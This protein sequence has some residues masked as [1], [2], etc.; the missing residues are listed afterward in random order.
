MIEWSPPRTIGTGP[1]LATRYT[2]SWITRSARSK[3][4][5]TTGASPASTTV[6]F[7]YGS[8]SSWIDHASA[9]PHAVGAIRIAR[10]PNRAPGRDDVPSSNGAPTIATSAFAARSASSVNAHGSFSNEPCQSA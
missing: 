5:G 6:S 3:R 7:A 4:V 1:A 10:G 9:V 8:A 2:F